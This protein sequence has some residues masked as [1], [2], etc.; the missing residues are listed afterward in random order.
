MISF[1][2]FLTENE[3]TVE[4]VAALLRKECAPYL[5]YIEGHHPSTWLKRGWFTPPPAAHFH[6]RT[7]KNRTP[8]DMSENIHMLLDNMLLHQQGDKFRS[9]AIFCCVSAEIASSYG[10]EVFI[11]L[12]RG[13]FRYCWSPIIEDAYAF[14][15]YHK[16]GS[17]PQGVSEMEI[18]LGK[19]F[20]PNTTDINVASPEW[21]K[22][23]AEYLNKKEPYTS[24]GL[25]TVM[26]RRSFHKYEVMLVCESA[27]YIMYNSNPTSQKNGEDAQF[28]AEVLN[29]LR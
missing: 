5:N 10:D 14:F 3:L 26:N 24:T 29:A 17:A 28:A 25:D 19:E 27:Y 7:R 8:V 18:A 13:K 21:L 23:M 9:E 22:F 2:Q 16:H 11:V 4:E 1:K 6:A 12:P 15:D 20:N